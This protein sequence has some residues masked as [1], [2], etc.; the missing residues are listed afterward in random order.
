MVTPLGRAVLLAVALFP[1]SALSDSALDI[2]R[3]QETQERTEALLPPDRAAGVQAA[4]A[5]KTPAVKT[6]TNF[7]QALRCMDD[8]FLGFD[9]RGIVITSAG[10]PD[11]TGKVRTGTKEMLITAISKMTVKSGAFDFIDFHSQGDD[12][13]NLFAMTGGAPTKMPD[14]YIRGSITQMDDNAV[15]NTKG[16][17]IAFPFLD[18]GF[19]KD[20]AFDLISMDMSVG[21]AASR[22]ILP[23]TSTS[24]TMVISKGGRSGEAGGRIGKAG[25]S[26]SLDLSRSEGLGATTRTLIE[27]G[28][29][30]TLGKFT[31]VPYW[32]CLDI[33]STN[34]VMMDQA[35]EGFDALPLKE[36]VLFVQ[37]K[38]GG[39][40]NRYKGPLDGVMSEQ[41][42]NAIAEYQKDVGL[43]ADGRL[44]FDLYYSLLD[45]IQNQLAALPLSPQKPAPLPTMAAQQPAPPPPAAAAVAPQAQAQA[46]AMPFQVRLESERGARPTYRVGEFLNMNL[47]LSAPGT[48]FCYY[49]DVARNTARIFPNQFY[50]NSM[51]NAGNLMRLPSGGFKIKFDRP[52]RERVACI[53]DNREVVVP[54]TLKGTRDLARLPVR[55]LDEVIGL[56]R[57]VNPSAIASVVEITVQ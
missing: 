1:L 26:F 55:S 21:E 34:P 52:G 39:S 47:S 50:S 38:L 30:E 49:E 33:E 44:N 9:K 15:R 31:R 19:S 42:K 56:F 29:I 57:Q 3:S 10:I 35:R 2:G 37:R 48:V 5:P 11:E 12:L 6:I 8:L 17:G 14:F 54:Q 22:R 7:S 40:M 18:L 27:L 13:G 53:G 32:K 45:D 36:R 24:N 25:L 46:H 41:L 16:F 43:I 20:D 23:E 4:S 51:L 28:L